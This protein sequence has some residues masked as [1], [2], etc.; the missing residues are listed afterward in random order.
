MSEWAGQI[1]EIMNDSQLP[2]QMRESLKNEV[3]K[4][5]HMIKDF[6]KQIKTKQPSLLAKNLLT[7]IRRLNLMAIG[8][9]VNTFDIRWFNMVL[10]VGVTVERVSQACPETIN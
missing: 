5:L 10:H 8:I 6:G 2:A 4:V 1:Q 7:I 3:N 9:Y